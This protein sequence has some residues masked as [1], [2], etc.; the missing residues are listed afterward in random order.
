VLKS[1]QSS[2]AGLDDFERGQRC[3]ARHKARLCR[4]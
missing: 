1:T 3:N 4:D 2:E